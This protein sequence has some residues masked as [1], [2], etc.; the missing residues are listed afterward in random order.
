MTRP[1]AFER[2]GDQV[3]EA[4]EAGVSIADAGRA[5]D[6]APR[7]IYRWL[8]RGRKEREG[9]F[10]SFAQAV[11]RSREDRTLTSDKPLDERELRV[12]VSEAAR[13]GSVTAMRLYWE[14]LRSDRDPASA[15]NTLAVVDELARRRVAGD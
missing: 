14:I 9:P 12:R 10:A 3:L 11:D 7:T 8:A 2:V 1:E 13:A 6:V 5:S 15:D 4:I